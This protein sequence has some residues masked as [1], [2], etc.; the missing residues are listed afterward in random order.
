MNLKVISPVSI[1]GAF[2]LIF[3][4]APSTQTTISGSLAL[5]MYD[6][7][8]TL[9]NY[10][11]IKVT[12]NYEKI[13]VHKSNDDENSWIVVVSN[14]GTISN[15]LELTSNAPAT[16]GVAQLPAGHYTQ[17]R[18]DIATNH[19]LVYVYNGTTNE[20]I[21][22]LPVGTNSSVKIVKAFDVDTNET[23]ELHLD[24]EASQS[25]QLTSG[26][27]PTFRLVPVIRL[28]KSIKKGI[29]NTYND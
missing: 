10:E 15:L 13:L 27:S 26:A 1:I 2:L 8:I 7:P 18:I 25:I 23:T 9:Q 6:A 3:S 21:L 17:I 5:K 4:C 12:I 20:A 16:L 24:F 28:A 11:I 29:T 14:A 19:S 22:S